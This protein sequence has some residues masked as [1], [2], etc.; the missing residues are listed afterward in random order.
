M[1]QAKR[2]TRNQKEAIARR[3]MNPEEWML[4]EEGDGYMTLIRKSTGK[5]QTIGKGETEDD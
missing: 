1:K 4:L 5:V 3:K 2:L